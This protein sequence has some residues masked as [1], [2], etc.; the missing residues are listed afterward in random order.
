[1]PQSLQPSLKL[2]DFLQKVTS[3]LVPMANQPSSTDDDFRSSYND[4][5]ALA[6][7]SGPEL[8]SCTYL[9]Y[10]LLQLQRARTS[11]AWP[12]PSDHR[13]GISHNHRFYQRFRRSSK[14]KR[15]WLRNGS[16]FVLRLT[17]A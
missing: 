9:I 17:V 2:I 14:F 8:Q 5:M 16:G 11:K 7:L 4:P 3:A 15:R 6:A 12:N 1:M 10:A 13:A